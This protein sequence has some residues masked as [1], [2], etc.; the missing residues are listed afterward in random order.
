MSKSLDKATLNP[1]KRLFMDGCGYS[2]EPLVIPGLNT[3]V[4]FPIMVRS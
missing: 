4:F 2:L 1:G 3:A